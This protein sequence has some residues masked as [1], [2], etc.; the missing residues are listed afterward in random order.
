MTTIVG[1]ICFVAGLNIGILVT[2]CIKSNR[3]ESK[4]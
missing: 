4:H 1:I 3:E 2:A